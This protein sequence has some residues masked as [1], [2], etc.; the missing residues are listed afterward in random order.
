MQW[1]PNLALWLQQTNKL[2]LLTYLLTPPSD[3][4]GF[5]LMWFGSLVV[6]ALDSR[7]EGREF[8]SRPPRL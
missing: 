8:D 1:V 2:Y 3:C 4:C 6:S 5:R 7:L